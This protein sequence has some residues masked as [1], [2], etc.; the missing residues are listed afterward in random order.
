M[1]LSDHFVLMKWGIKVHVFALTNQMFVSLRLKAV[2]FFAELFP[3]PSK[4]SVKYK[5]LS[6]YE[7][8][9]FLQEY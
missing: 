9:L 2:F 6:R 4:H 1:L 5:L 7:P 3:R 8:L